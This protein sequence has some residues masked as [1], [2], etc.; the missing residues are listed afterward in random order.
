MTEISLD[1]LSE[2]TK[3][4]IQ[5]I[6]IYEQTFQ[7]ILMEKRAFS[8]EIEELENAKK[9]IEKSEGEMFK[10]LAGQYVLKTDKDYLIKE[11]EHK[12]EILSLRIKN[13]EKQEKTYSEKMETLRKEIL[14]EINN[15]I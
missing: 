15:E 12:K 9:E 11:I 6:Q 7:Q 4:K 14:K 2:E 1:N 8:L 3:R 5:E 10:I 13:L